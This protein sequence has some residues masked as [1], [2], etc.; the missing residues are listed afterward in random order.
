MSSSA[1]A[2]AYRSRATTHATISPPYRT[3]STAI[4]GCSGM[5]MSGVTGQAQGSEPCSA[6]K[7]APE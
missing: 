1:S 3:V 5:T 2:A 6:A 4:D 7:S